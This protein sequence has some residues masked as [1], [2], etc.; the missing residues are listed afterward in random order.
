M[1]KGANNSYFG[2][3]WEGIASSWQGLKLSLKHIWEARQR[4]TP[5]SITDPDYFKQETG[6]VTLTYPYESL[7][8]PDNG[9]YRLHNE[10][11][12]CIVCDKCAEICPVSC[13]DIE[14]VK[15]TEEIRKTSD[16]HSVRLYAAR[17]D[18]DM[19]KCCF[20]GLCTTVCPTECLTM[21]KTY[22][23]SEFDIRDMI[24]HFSD[25]SPE[26]A[27]EKRQNYEA[28]QAAKQQAKNS[29][30]VPAIQPTEEKTVE[31]TASTPTTA[32]PVMKKPAIKPVTNPIV[33]DS[34]PSIPEVTPTVTEV[35]PETSQATQ[36]VSPQDTKTEEANQ[37]EQAPSKPVM[38]KPIIKPMIKKKTDE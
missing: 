17:F 23:F 35:T 13:I 31:Q 38:K 16:G 36:E 15:S 18:I 28:V 8:V 1:Q 10:M 22:D 37:P 19:A 14:A 3:I 26:Q 25:L 7:P 4:R 27:V 32:K 30:S 34:T 12:D 11:E 20:C 24:Y 9:R 6:I 29:V 21:T 5:I 33:T 2:N